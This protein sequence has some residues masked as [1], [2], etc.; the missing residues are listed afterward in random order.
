M[1]LL[2]LEGSGSP[3]FLPLLENGEEIL[4]PEYQAISQSCSALNTSRTSMCSPLMN[5][6]SSLQG[7]FFRKS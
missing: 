4:P 5:L 6:I 2:L 3:H 7:M 1:G